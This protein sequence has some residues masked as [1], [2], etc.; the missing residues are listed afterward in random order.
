MPATTDAPNVRRRGF[1]ADEVHRMVEAGILREDERLELIDG[2][3]NVAD[4]L[5]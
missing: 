2:D 3:W 4:L 5:P 1:T